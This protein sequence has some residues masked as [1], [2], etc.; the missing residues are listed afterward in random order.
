[1]EVFQER[2][3]RENPVCPCGDYRWQGYYWHR[4]SVVPQYESD[5]WGKV[6]DPDGKVRD[7]LEAR[8]YYVENMKVEISFVNSLKPGRILDLGCGPDF[9]LSA[10]HDDWEKYG[11]D[12]SKIATSFA[13]KYGTIFVGELPEAKYETN[14]FDVVN[15]SMLIEHLEDPISYLREVNKDTKARRIFH[16]YYSG[17]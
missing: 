16:S 14:F 8:D 1:M 5:F 10:I 6:P 15:M 2:T 13:K 17:L 7:E 12:I 4:P 3:F 9:F 11:V